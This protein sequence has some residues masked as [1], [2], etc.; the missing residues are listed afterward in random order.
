MSPGNAADVK[1][2]TMN[3]SYHYDRSDDWNETHNGIFLQVDNWTVGTYENSEWH[4]SQYVAYSAPIADSKY[5]EW[6][7][8]GATGYEK[9]PVMPLV[10]VKATYH[11]VYSLITPTVIAVGLSIPIGEVK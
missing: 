8:G 9:L 4:R 5:F 10:G 1:I 7:V 6:T 3:Y 2:G 11:Y